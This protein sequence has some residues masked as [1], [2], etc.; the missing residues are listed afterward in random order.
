MIMILQAVIDMQMH[1]RSQPCRKKKTYIKWT[2]LTLKLGLDEKILERS[3]VQSNALWL[4]L[5][6]RSRV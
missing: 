6:S 3:T 4:F 1:L 5:E 2:I